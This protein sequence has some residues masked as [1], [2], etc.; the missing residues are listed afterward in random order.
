MHEMKTAH[1]ELAAEQQKKLET[2]FKEIDQITTLKLELDKLVDSK[3]A[4]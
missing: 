3:T 2:D 4:R 1:E